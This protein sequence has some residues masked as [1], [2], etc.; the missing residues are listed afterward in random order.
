MCLNC[1][2]LQLTH[3]NNYDKEASEF[4][5]KT[6]CSCCKSF[7]NFCK[8]VNGDLKVLCLTKMKK[9]EKNTCPHQT[10]K[11]KEFEGMVKRRISNR[12]NAVMAQLDDEKDKI[13]EGHYLQRAN[14]LK[15]FNDFI[16]VLD[17]ADDNKPTEEQED[18]DDGT[19]W[20]GTLDDDFFEDLGITPVFE[21]QT[22]SN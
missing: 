4:L 8:E 21:E 1:L 18:S 5:E 20:D 6:N 17:E 19:D 16:A 9:Y 10:E 7:P 3:I 15:I 2:N 14:D 11:I 13:Q 22:D 12:L